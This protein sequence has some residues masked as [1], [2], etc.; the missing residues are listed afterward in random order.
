MEFFSTEILV[1]LIYAELGYRTNG[2]FLFGLHSEEFLYLKS[3][4]FF[5]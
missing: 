4:P 1:R 5:N 2:E 3:S